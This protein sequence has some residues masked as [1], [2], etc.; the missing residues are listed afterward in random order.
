MLPNHIRGLW[1]SN[2]KALNG[3]LSIPNSFTAEIMAEQ[4]YDSI[5]ID[6]QHGVVD[7]QTSLGMF[8]AM[9]ASGVTPMARVPWLDAGQIMKALDTGAYGIICPMIN[10]RK[11]AEEFV[12]YLRYPPNG[13]RSYGPTRAVISAGPNYRFEAD[14]QVVG[15]AMI[16]TSEAMSNLNEIVATPGLDAVYIGPADLAIDLTGK[17]YQPGFDREEPEVTDAIQKILTA[18]HS[19]GIRAALHCGSPEY[20]LK[21]LGWGFDLVT[22]SNDVRLLTAA[23]TASVRQVREGMASVISETPA[24]Q[25]GGY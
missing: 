20:A 12:S 9:R 7:G 1:S 5:T 15:F 11:Q 24:A 10:S 21:A 19:A 6:L 18:A 16:E 4:G 17:K 23:A 25:T 13:V 22:V 8:Q 14:E 3:W 2:Q